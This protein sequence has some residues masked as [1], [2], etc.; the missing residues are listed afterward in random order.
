MA[1]PPLVLRVLSAPEGSALAR[2]A[3]FP[4]QGPEAVVGRSPDADVVLPD[5]TVSRRHLRLTVGPPIRVEALTASNG[6]FVDGT[7]LELGTPVSVGVG[8]A[9]LQ[10][11]GVLLAVV[12]LAETEPVLEPLRSPSQGPRHEPLLSVQWDAGQCLTRCRG[13]DLGLTGAAAR[14]LGL[15]AEQAGEVVHHWDL[16]QELDTPHLAPLATAA[17]H[18]L[19]AAVEAGVLSELHLRERLQAAGIGGPV[20]EALPPAELMRAVLQARRG[21]GYV[22]HLHRTDVQVTRV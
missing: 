7:P 20:S 9:R 13:R 10:L 22:L 17:R 5:N 11:G 4:L 1:P 16:Q 14:F 6:T 2:G 12:P 8:G 21:H 18:A 15:L 19:M 3:S